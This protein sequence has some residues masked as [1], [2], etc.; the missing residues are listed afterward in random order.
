MKKI[1]LTI[2]LVAAVA[3]SAMA[4]TAISAGYL[5]NTQ[6]G[7]TS[8]QFNGFYVGLDYSIP[9]A[10]EFK[11]TPG[12][13]YDMLMSS[14]TATV[15]V[16][17]AEAKTTEHYIAVPVNLSYGFNLGDAIKLFF[18]AGPTFSYGLA[19]TVDGSLNIAGIDLGKSGNLYGED[20]TYA[21]FNVFVGGGAGLEFNN[22]IRFTAGYNYGCFDR[23]TSDSLTLTDSQIH[24]GISFL[25]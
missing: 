15:S 21:R 6:K 23:N 3:T 22:K 8:T 19:S 2:A 16:L 13:Y 24:A 10:G 20:S 14:K 18:Y 1:L 4:Q 12:I 7:R 5:N 17:N 9:I 25:F 11:L